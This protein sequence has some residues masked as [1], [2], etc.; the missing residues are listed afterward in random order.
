MAQKKIF[1][2]IAPNYYNFFSPTFTSQKIYE[3]SLYEGLLQENSKNKAVAFFC[4]SYDFS[5]NSY[6]KKKIFF[7]APNVSNYLD[8]IEISQKIYQFS[9][10][11]G[12]LKEGPKHKV[13]PGG[14]M[15]VMRYNGSKKKNFFYC[16]QLFQR[17]SSYQNKPE[18]ILVWS[19]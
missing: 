5:G 17:F 16:P 13:S 7:F 6:S 11:E 9:L 15:K 18:N 8:P 10:Y 1:F 3:S 19:I 2:F 12:L 4:P 14:K